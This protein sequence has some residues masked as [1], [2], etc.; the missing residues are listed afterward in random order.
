MEHFD[1]RKVT[2]LVIVERFEDKNGPRGQE[3][4][5]KVDKIQH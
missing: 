4:E 2:T 3:K 5:G 1:N